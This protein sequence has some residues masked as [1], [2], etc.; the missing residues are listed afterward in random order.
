MRNKRRVEHE[1]IIKYFV[2]RHRMSLLSP[3]WM[4]ASLLLVRQQLL[5]TKSQSVVCLPSIGHNTSLRMETNL[6][7]KLRS[8]YEAR[9]FKLLVT[10][11]HHYR[12][13]SSHENT[14]HIITDLANGARGESVGI[15]LDEGESNFHSQRLL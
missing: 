10:S 14:S 12:D 3:S 2:L 1:T 9:D 13:C 7:G 8:R 5:L 4:V 15:V 6:E 11:T